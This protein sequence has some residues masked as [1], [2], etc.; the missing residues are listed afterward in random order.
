M[1]GVNGGLLSHIATE[2]RRL[3]I[4]KEILLDFR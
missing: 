2:Y 1:E 4:K 3:L